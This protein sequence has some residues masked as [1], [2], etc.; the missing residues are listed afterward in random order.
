MKK[1]LTLLVAAFVMQT[2]FAQQQKKKSTKPKTKTEATK[3]APAL[4]A[5]KEK[6]PCDSIVIDFDKGTLNKLTM[7]DAI[8]TIKKYLP[9]FSEVFAEGG[10]DKCG[11]GVVYDKLGFFA[12]TA[13]DYFEFLPASSKLLPVN[14]FGKTEEEWNTTFG[15]PAQISDYRPYEASSWSVYLYRKTYGTLAIWWSNTDKKFFKV[16]MYPLP[17]EK[18]DFC[19]D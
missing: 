12:N 16:Q 14:P 19:F 6:N 2:S 5:V 17:F 11:G 10:E 1:I 15:D 18:L 7:T 13:R 9:C 8:D 3:P 4:V